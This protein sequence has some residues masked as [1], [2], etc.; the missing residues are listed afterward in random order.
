MSFSKITAKPTIFLNNVK[1]QKNQL[2]NELPSC[3]ISRKSVEEQ[4][5][6]QSLK[7]HFFPK[8]SGKTDKTQ[9]IS[10]DINNFK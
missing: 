10:L 8:K 4:K 9:I 6:Y 2:G 1:K 3:Q 5:S 7:L